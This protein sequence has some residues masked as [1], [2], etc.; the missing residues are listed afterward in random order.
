SG[1]D[2]VGLHGAGNQFVG[3]SIGNASNNGYLRSSDAA[4]LTAAG[5]SIVSIYERS[6]TTISYFTT[7]N[8]L[9]DAAHAISAA[10]L[11]GQPL[12]SAI[13]FTI[14][15]D[16]SNQSDIG[17]IKSY[18]ETISSYFQSHGAPFKI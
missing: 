8:A 3:E 6:P 9:F 5:L 1:I 10:N 13:Y 2:I 14:D 7:D 15:A 16:F 11:A 12:G 4:L 17:T 18:F